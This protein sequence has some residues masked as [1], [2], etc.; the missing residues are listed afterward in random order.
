MNDSAPGDLDAWGLG[1]SAAATADLAGEVIGRVAREHGVT[2]PRDD[3]VMLV[4]QAFD[5]LLERRLSTLIAPVGADLAR[6]QHD[7]ATRLQEAAQAASSQVQV[8]T[9][10]APPLK[11]TGGRSRRT[12]PGIGTS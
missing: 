11:P 5:G 10:T 12:W 4:V 9:P 7:A 2:I 6:L 8:D 1:A 3:P